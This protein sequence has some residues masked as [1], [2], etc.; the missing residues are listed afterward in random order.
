MVSWFCRHFNNHGCTTWPCGWFSPGE[1]ECERP[2][3]CWLEQ[4]RSSASFVLLNFYRWEV[5][6]LVFLFYQ[7]RRALKNLRV[8]V[9]PSNREYKISGLSEN[10]CKEQM[11][12]KCI[13]FITCWSRFEM[14]LTGLS[15]ADTGSL[16]ILRTIWAKLWSIRRLCLSISPTSVTSNC[17]TLVTSLAS[18]LANQSALLTSPLR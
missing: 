16:G 15:L 9:A 6:Y 7:A 2:L 5:I 12:V 4:G 10:R 11:Y 14:F 13:F 17:S 1:S 8:K 18:T 3:L